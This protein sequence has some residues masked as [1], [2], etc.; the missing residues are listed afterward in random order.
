MST[1]FI[2]EYAI[3]GKDTNGRAMQVP[4]EPPLAEQTI[5]IGGASVQSNAFNA[6]TGLIRVHTD[7]ICS[8]VIGPNPTA[9]TA[10]G[11]MAANTTEYTAID[12]QVVNPPAL[13][14]AVIAN[15]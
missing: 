1:L 12:T 10:K 11:R 2:T 9:T 3:V 4:Q 14:L 13:K 8:K 7:V 6:R 15:T 5:A